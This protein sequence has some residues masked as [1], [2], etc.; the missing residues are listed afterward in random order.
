MGRGNRLTLGLSSIVSTLLALMDGLDA[1]GQVVV[2]GATNR[3]DAVDPALRRPGRF[4]RELPFTLPDAASREEILRVHTSGWGR[5]A[6]GEPGSPG[7][8]AA[9][10]SEPKPRRELR[11]LY[12]KNAVA[13]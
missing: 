12:R 6:A 2:L 4:D 5:P 1:R 13:A 9:A 10:A 8:L 11:E 7:E 3:P